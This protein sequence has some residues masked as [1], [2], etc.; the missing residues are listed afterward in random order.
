MIV[1]RYS[2]KYMTVTPDAKGWAPYLPILLTL[3]LAHEAMAECS[4]QHRLAVWSEM[5]TGMVS[6]YL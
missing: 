6:N 2:L 4:L 1:N 5:Y 3:E